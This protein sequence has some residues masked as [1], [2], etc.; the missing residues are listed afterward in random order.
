MITERVISSITE[1]FNQ[2]E[3]CKKKVPIVSF[4]I[5]G[6]DWRNIKKYGKYIELSITNRCNMSCEI[7]FMKNACGDFE[8]EEM[9]LEDIKNL[10]KKIGK[11]KNITLFGGEPTIRNDLFEIIDF[12]SNSGNTAVLFT[13]GIKLADVD[14]VKK[15]AATNLKKIFLSI[16][17]LNGKHNV[18]LEKKIKAIQNLKKFANNINL[19]LSVTVVEKSTG[20]LKISS[21]LN[22]IENNDFIQGIV[23]LAPVSINEFDRLLSEIKMENIIDML[24]KATSGK[25]NKEY[26]S[27]F[28]EL[29]KNLRVFF[30][31]I[32]IMFPVYK[33]NIYLKKENGKLIPFIDLKDIKEINR[34]FHS[35]NYLGLLRYVYIYI[36]YVGILKK[37]FKPSKLEFEA[38]K[39]DLIN[40]YI[41]YPKIPKHSST[42]RE[43]QRVNIAKFNDESRFRTM[44]IL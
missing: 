22:F 9:L 10:I 18:I 24:D 5:S 17:S 8:F 25:I 27:E 29:R 13:N 12:I 38:Y 4:P 44:M 1:C 3:S 39:K 41:T 36:H 28:F 11:N 21:F 6:S 37:I 14:Y 35:K 40:I 2:V 30:S 16:D 7:C 32:K 23:F 31:L 33:H 43:F 26:F 19:Y 42:K 20:I 34:K 15:L